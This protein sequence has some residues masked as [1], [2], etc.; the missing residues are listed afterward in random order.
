MSTKFTLGPWRVGKAVNGNWIEADHA[1][2]PQS[3]GRT[4]Y[5]VVGHEVEDAN[6]HLIASAPDL[7]GALGE[8][9]EAMRILSEVAEEVRLEGADKLRGLEANGRAALAKA[10][11]EAL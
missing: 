8:A 1:C 7:Y 9:V 4:F 2:S 6:A 10:R 5:E 11:G 3:I